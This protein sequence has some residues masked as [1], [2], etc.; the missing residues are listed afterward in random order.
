MDTSIVFV[1]G[2]NMA[3]SL[4][5]GLRNAD[6]AGD[7][8]T[9]IEP[10]EAKGEQLAKDYGVNTVA[11]ADAQTLK[12]DVIVLAVKPQMLREVAQGLVEPLGDHKPLFVSIAAGVP[13]AG[14]REWLG[15]DHAYVRCMPNTPS[16]IGAGATG[17]YA[18]DG[19]SD[20]QRKL[21]DAILETA[22]VTAWVNDE[23]LLDAVTATS[24][25]G[26]AYF[27]AFMEAMQA[28]AIELGLD[29]ATARELVLHTALGAAR[30]AIESGD[31]PATLREKVTSPGG[32]TAAA[33]EQYAEGDLNALV[34]RAMQAAASRADRLATELLDK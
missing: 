25:S 4:I 3:T 6:W 5:S 28:G 31:D 22:G 27:F 26:P 13:I 14:L 24:G 34:G 30:M 17:L 16:L 11:Q 8:I 7:R 20:E 23:S 29:E 10:D 2:G 9:V 19:V 12:A 21:A 33:L 32:T 18:D 1:G 15:A